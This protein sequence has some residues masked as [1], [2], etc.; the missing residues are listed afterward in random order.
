MHV[1][2]VGDAASRVLLME[3]MPSTL[4]RRA[5]PPPKTTLKLEPGYRDS[6]DPNHHLALLYLKARMIPTQPLSKI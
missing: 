6:P 5:F 1:I 2:N 3:V 4:A